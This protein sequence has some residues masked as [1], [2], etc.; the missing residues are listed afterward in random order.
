MPTKKSFT[1]TCDVCGKEYTAKKESLAMEAAE[2]CEESH[3][4]VYVPLLKSDV[5]RLLSF[6]VTRN[7]DFLTESLVETLHEY[8]NL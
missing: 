6:I 1:V 2:K 7:D 8:R 5:Q 4:I 3:D